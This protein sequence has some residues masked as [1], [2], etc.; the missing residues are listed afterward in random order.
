[1]TRATRW[2]LV[3]GFAVLAVAL[4][5]AGS[6]AATKAAFAGPTATFSDSR[7]EIAGGPDIGT[8][9]VS[10]DG[11]VLTIDADVAGMPQLFSEGTTLFALNTDGDRTTGSLQGADYLVFFDMKDMSSSVMRWNGSDYGDADKVADPSRTLIGGSSA[12][13]MFNLANFGSPRRIEFM[14]VVVR[15]SLDGGLIDTA[16]DTGLWA[17]DTTTP[18]PTPTPTPTP[19]PVVVRPVFGAARMVPAKPLAGKK[20]VFTLAVRRSDTGAPLTTGRMICDPS[21]AGKVLPHAESFT[22]GTA[23]L[24]FVVPKTA[25]GKQLKVKVTIKTG[26]QSGTSVTTFRVR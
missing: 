22:N 14:I 18:A 26:T 20:V 11:Q 17:F 4:F 5:V 23:R 24:A 21:V 19:T 2:V 1:M 12:G 15:G 13:L 3:A 9:T 7:G 10:V 25:K 8:V 16:P 6:T